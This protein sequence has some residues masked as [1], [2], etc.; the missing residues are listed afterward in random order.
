MECMHVHSGL[1]RELGDSSNG[2]LVVLLGKLVEEEVCQVLNARVGVLQAQSHSC[3]VPLH[4]HH[5]IH[6]QMGQNHQAVLS[7]PCIAYPQQMVMFYVIHFGLDCC[8]NAISTQSNS[9]E[10]IHIT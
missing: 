7:Y 9:K 4:L 8:A 5:V 6:D 10:S 2:H 3:N 1:A